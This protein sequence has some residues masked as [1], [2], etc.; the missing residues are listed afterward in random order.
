MEFWE[1]FDSAFA[2]KRNIAYD[3][4]TIS[5]IETT[6]K[7]LGNTLFVDR[8][9][10]ALNIEAASS[11]YPP[12]GH[13]GLREL[14]NQIVSSSFPAREK[15]SILYYILR[16]LAEPNTLSQFAERSF[17]PDNYRIFVDG[18][19]HLDNLQF[20]NALRCLTDPSLIPTFPDEILYAFCVLPKD[21]DKFA[22]AYYLS[23]SPPLATEKAL[24]AFFTV[25]CRTSVTDAF[26]F[27]RKQ[28]EP[29]RRK[30]LDSLVSSILSSRPGE[31][32]SERASELINLPFDE[33]E[34]EIFEES[35]LHGSAKHYSGSK[36]TLLMRR[37][38][39]GNLSHLTSG[40]ENVAGRRLDGLNWDDFKRNLRPA[41]S[42]T[43]S[44]PP[45]PPF[46]PKVQDIIQDLTPGVGRPTWIF[47][48]YAPGKDAPVQL[49]EGPNRE[50]SP[51]EMRVMHYM[52]VESNTVQQAIEHVNRL[53]TEIEA[54]MNS[55]LKNTDTAIKYIVDGEQRHPNRWD[56]IDALN[57]GTANPINQDHQLQ[58]QLQQQQQ[59]QQTD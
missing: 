5:Q 49:F 28:P 36:D 45:R 48:S 58:L 51:E 19:W 10:T 13:S 35:L 44:A 43:A 11:L 37:I 2:F 32:R 47:S 4:Q 38:A 31:K 57:A 41:S 9:L 55:I 56:I 24:H 50:I 29:L 53:Y 15:Q 40:L 54:Q 23:T 8:L 34:E 1:D 6:R 46:F 42:S 12:K 7:T 18:L 22:I 52:A 27:T 39:I 33:S 59:Q 21:N 25:L 16:D 26:Y 14:H 17:L 30:L 3:P 20:H